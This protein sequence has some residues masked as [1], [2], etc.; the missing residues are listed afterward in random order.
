MHNCQLSMLLH[1][2][3]KV[4]HSNYISATCISWISSCII[5][6]QT[7]KVG[8]IKKV[9]AKIS[10]RVHIPFKWWL[11]HCTLFNAQHFH[12]KHACMIILAFLYDWSVHKEW[13]LPI[14]NKLPKSGYFLENFM[15]YFITDWSWCFVVLQKKS[16]YVSIA[17][18]GY[19]G[20]IFS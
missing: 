3:G 13:V 20:I 4:Y 2:F 15:S 5:R 9:F 7:L 12:S 10:V 17:R 16:K 8:P 1:G 14:T 6:L 11:I 18:G 19:Q